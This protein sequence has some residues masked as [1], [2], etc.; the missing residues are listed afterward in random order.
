[1]NIPRC[2][3]HE[4]YI[5]TNSEQT[6]TIASIKNNKQGEYFSFKQNQQRVRASIRMYTCPLFK[7]ETKS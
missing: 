4:Q 7:C 6:Q 2:I 5:S 1:M 3:I